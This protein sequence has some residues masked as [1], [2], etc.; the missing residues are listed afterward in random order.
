MHVLFVSTVCVCVLYC[1]QQCICDLCGMAQL[2]LSQ[3][4]TTVEIEASNNLSPSSTSSCENGSIISESDVKVE[5]VDLAADERL[6]RC[7]Q[8]IENENANPDEI[9][10]LDQVGNVSSD[11]ATSLSSDNA[12]SNNASLMDILAIVDDVDNVEQ[13][14]AA[15]R[16]LLRTFSRDAEE[17]EESDSEDIEE[18]LFWMRLMRSLSVPPEEQDNR[19]PE[20]CQVCLVE[21][22]L[23]KRPCCQQ[24]VC[25]D[26]LQ[27][28]VETQLV[29]VGIVRIGCPNPSCDRGMY[30]DEVRELL[31]AKPDLRDRYDRWLVDVNA[32]PHRKTCPRC[33]KVTDVEPAQLQDR[34]VAKFGLQVQCSEC[35]LQWCFPCQAPWHQ[36]LTCKKFRTGDI[37]LKQW[38]HQRIRPQ[39]YNAQRCPKCKVSVQVSHLLIFLPF[40]WMYCQYISA[41]LCILE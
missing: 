3:H 33:C 30:Q 8:E 17:N 7:L 41:L 4:T 11:D 13:F 19:V 29:D 26:C 35:E 14:L 10:V 39:E 1:R 38:A 32:D 20:E 12:A 6:A 28:Y 36:G 22:K 21:V 37:L 9:M 2:Q 23:N 34:H 25:D 40:S 27:Q 16:E 24:A 31:R 5:E 15:Q 18:R